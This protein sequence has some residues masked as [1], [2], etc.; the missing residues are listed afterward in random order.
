MTAGSDR[1]LDGVLAYLQRSR[2][3]DFTPYKRP[4]LL[5]RI[6]QRMRAVGLARA[7]AYFERLRSDPEE[8]AAL[9]NAIFVNVTA[10]Y[11]DA[12]MWE[13]LETKVLPALA[14]LSAA[15]PIRIWSAGCASGEEPFTAAMLLAEWLGADAFHE[16]VTIFA[17]DVD[18]DALTQARRALFTTRQLDAVPAPLRE[19][20]FTRCGDGL[21]AF[22]RDLRRSVVFRPHDVINEAPIPQIDLLL[23]RNTLMYFNW[24]AQR[25]TIGRLEAALNSGG[26]LVLGPA[27]LLCSD[28]LAFTPVDLERRI[29]QMTRKRAPL[30]THLH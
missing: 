9:I 14:P 26:V 18:R 30:V 8:A 1:G 4:S 19:K 25:R 3:F 10:F 22:D 12:S 17:T 28:T 13:V 5:R 24:D 20:Y 11:R 6:E 23:C 2:G 21:Y 7:D 27:E 15:A 16:R 29:F